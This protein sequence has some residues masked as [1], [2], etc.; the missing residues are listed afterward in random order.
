MV[1]TSCYCFLYEVFL[2]ICWKCD[3]NTHTVTQIM[4]KNARFL[5][6]LQCIRT[7]Q[8]TVVTERS[9]NDSH[10]NA[11]WFS[12]CHSRRSTLYTWRCTD[13]VK[14]VLLMMHVYSSCVAYIREFNDDIQRNVLQR[15]TDSTSASVKNITWRS[16]HIRD[17]TPTQETGGARAMCLQSAHYTATPI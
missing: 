5:F 14:G 12:S 11:N 6:R 8:V 13:V 9:D 10:A 3:E 15:P 7:E 4:K 16:V 17:A 2:H 1:C